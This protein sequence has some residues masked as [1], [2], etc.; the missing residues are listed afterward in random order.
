MYIN[1]IYHH[2][3][4]HRSWPAD[5][6]TRGN[7]FCKV[8]KVTA[9]TKYF[10]IPDDQNWLHKARQKKGPCEAGQTCKEGGQLKGQNEGW[11]W[12]QRHFGWQVILNGVP[13]EKWPPFFYCRFAQ[14]CVISFT[15]MHVF[16]HFGEISQKHGR[17]WALRS[18]SGR[19]ISVGTLM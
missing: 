12:I 10:S 3:S 11:D 6:F 18:I 8:T 7:F 15:N 1:V 19:S 13:L 9:E 4:F 5:L 16:C 2:L 14:N 17:Q